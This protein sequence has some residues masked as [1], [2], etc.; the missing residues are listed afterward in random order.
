MGKDEW[1]TDENYATNPAR[2]ENRKELIPMLNDLFAKRPADEWIELCLEIGLPAGPINDM[3]AVF[4]DPQVRAR[5][6]RVDVPHPTEGS[7]P[8]LASPLNVPTAP[9]SIRL[10]PPTLGQH[11]AEVLS[12][13]LGLSEE[14]IEKLRAD[15]IIGDRPTFM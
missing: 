15:Q 10:P 5:G 3:P 9:T 11:N 6:L 7:V 1:I 14:E 12:G 13:V 4:V 2:I 8:L